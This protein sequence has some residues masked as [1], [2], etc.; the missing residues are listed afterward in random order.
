MANGNTRGL[1]YSPIVKRED[2]SESNSDEI[3]LSLA[4]Y[5]DLFSDFDLR[6]YSYRSLSDDFLVEL[7]RASRDKEGELSLNLLLPKSMRNSYHEALI[8][9]R[10]IEHF[11]KHF[12]RQSKEKSKIFWQ[13]ALFI[14]FGMVLM[15]IAAYFLYYKEEYDVFAVSFLV[16]ILEP[17]SWFLFWEGLNLLIFESKKQSPDLQFYER[18]N[19]CKIIFGGQEK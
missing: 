2:S 16:V 17:G 5:D 19:S 8:K 10:L 7:K 18:M 11:K 3:V 14:L 1:F 15:G 6:Q 12:E 4:G 9:K 13:G